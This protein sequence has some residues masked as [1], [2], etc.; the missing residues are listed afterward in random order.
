M[1][2]SISKFPGTVHET[3]HREHSLF[4]ECLMLERLE[5]EGSVPAI[6][7]NTVFVQQGIIIPTV[8]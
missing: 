2:T 8:R 4:A 1:S 7:A 3:A 6:H 5:S